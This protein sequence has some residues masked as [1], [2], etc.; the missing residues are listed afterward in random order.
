MGSPGRVFA[1]CPGIGSFGTRCK[2]ERFYTEWDHA[3]RVVERAGR[4]SCAKWRFVCNDDESCREVGPGP[5][6]SGKNRLQ[7]LPGES[8]RSSED[9]TVSQV[10]S[11]LVGS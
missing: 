6:A 1:A 5:A 7:A 2:G 8:E 11:R 9:G 3:L 10:F 4:L